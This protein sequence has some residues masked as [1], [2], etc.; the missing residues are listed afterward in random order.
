MARVEIAD[1][2]LATLAKL[3]TRP[4]RVSSF[5]D[6]EWLCDFAKA[7]FAQVCIDMGVLVLASDCD[8][9]VSSGEWDQ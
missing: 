1:T 4:T 7:C 8:V 5:D 9:R 6:C 2:L 3:D